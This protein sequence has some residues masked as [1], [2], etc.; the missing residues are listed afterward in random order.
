MGLLEDLAGTLEQHPATNGQQHMSLV[1]EVWRRFGNS[2]EISKLL[3]SAQSHGLGSVV[4]SW[5][6]PGQKQSINADQAKGLVGEGWVKEIADRT[7]IPQ[8]VVAE[9]VA[10]FLPGV[11][12]KVSQGQGKANAA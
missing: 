9:A 4:E 10:K 5:M 11:V 6:K 2:S 8:S 1:Q 7:G 12:G 3:N